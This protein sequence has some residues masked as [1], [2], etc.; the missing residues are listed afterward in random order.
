MNI[1]GELNLVSHTYECATEERGKFSCL[2]HRQLLYCAAAGK[3]LRSTFIRSQLSRTYSEFMYFESEPHF[4]NVKISPGSLFYDNPACFASQEKEGLSARGNYLYIDD[5]G[6]G[7]SLL[8]LKSTIYSGYLG[9]PGMV[10]SLKEH[11]SS[12][13]KRIASLFRIEHCVPARLF[14]RELL[15]DFSW[16]AAP[17]FLL[18]GYRFR[19]FT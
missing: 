12:V 17:R 14:D 7:S 10:R 9:I 2:L 11:G 13:H 15:F 6:K 4:S 1:L 19:E 18:A 8:L 3:R 16:R 5:R